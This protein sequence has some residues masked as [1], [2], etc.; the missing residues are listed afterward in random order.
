MARK[1]SRNQE[2]QA[3]RPSLSSCI[4]GSFSLK[5]LCAF[6][7]G[8]PW[9]FQMVAFPYSER[10]SIPAASTRQSHQRFSAAREPRKVPGCG[11]IRGI[12]L[13]RAFSPERIHRQSSA[14]SGLILSCAKFR[15]VW[16]SFR[17]LIRR[18]IPA[19]RAGRA[20]IGADPPGEYGTR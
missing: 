8:F 16:G 10:S 6:S 11:R 12:Q 7:V 1:S 2:N 17:L 19:R 9:E 15:P 3:G 4:E 18:R 5:G 14:R 13:A 20:R